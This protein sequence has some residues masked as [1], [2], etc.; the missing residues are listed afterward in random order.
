MNIV[1]KAVN[2]DTKFGKGLD[3]F[4][5]KQKIDVAKGLESTMFPGLVEKI[6]SETLI[7]EYQ[8]INSE[9]QNIYTDLYSVLDTN[10]DRYRNFFLNIFKQT[11]TSSE[12]VIKVLNTLS[13][14]WITYL[15][16]TQL[17]ETKPGVFIT[18]SKLYETTMSK[19]SKG[20]FAKRLNVIQKGGFYSKDPITSRIKNNIL[21]KSLTPMIFSPYSKVDNARLYNRNMNTE[22]DNSLLYAY[23]ELF[24]LKDQTNNKDYKY[25][26]ELLKYFPIIQNGLSMSYLTFTDK[27][28]VKE[29]LELFN[30]IKNSY[31][32]NF[33]KNPNV[34]IDQF[35][36]NNYKNDNIVPRLRKKLNSFTGFYESPVKNDNTVS[37]K[38]TDRKANYPYLKYSEK[39]EYF[40]ENDKKREPIKGE[41]I[42]RKIGRAHV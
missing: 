16:E 13:N 32:N 34:F 9:M 23:K 10:F 21:V 40:D 33:T 27:I 35:F 39:I 38:I 42:Y 37:V 41:P 31:A 25:F 36:R 28:P 20:S 15:L 14:D 12:D 26:I 24:D 11:N 7:G 19:E 5:Y 4:V 22:L 1:L 17:F 29:Y 6:Y 3:D 8:N 30:K 2:Q 18:L